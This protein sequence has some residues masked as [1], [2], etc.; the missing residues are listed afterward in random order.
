MAR[1]VQRL[2]V[3]AVAIICVGVIGAFALYYPGHNPQ[4]HPTQEYDAV[5]RLTVTQYRTLPRDAQVQ[6]MRRAI[7]G[8]AACPVTVEDAVRRIDRSAIT[9]LQADTLM[10]G[11]YVTALLARD[12]CA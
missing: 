5:T 10:T 4:D 6:F 8:V 7:A 2:L 11:R 3:S 12:G 1:S 9:P